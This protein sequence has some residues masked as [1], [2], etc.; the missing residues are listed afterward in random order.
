MAEVQRSYSES[1]ESF[2]SRQQQMNLEN[3][4]LSKLVMTYES[5]IDTLKTLIENLREESAIK[6]TEYEELLAKYNSAYLELSQSS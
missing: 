2:E 6:Q 1:N 3:L 4:N 5:E